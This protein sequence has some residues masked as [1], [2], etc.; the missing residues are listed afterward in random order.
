MM[1]EAI[2]VRGARVNNLKNI[3]FSIPLEKLT[4]VTGVSGSGKSSLAFDTICAGG[5]RRGG[6][7]RAAGARRGRGRGGG[8]G[9][10]RGG[11]RAPAGAGGRGA[12]GAGPRAA[13]G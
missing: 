9:G 13:G 12:A 6:G 5:R 2:T 8:P 7:A 4:V 1:E 11:G 3:S 10:D